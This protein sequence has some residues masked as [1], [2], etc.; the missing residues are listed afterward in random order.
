MFDAVNKVLGLVREVIRMETM[1]DS[2]RLNLVFMLLAFVVPLG[3]GVLDLAQVLIRLWNPTY[4]TGLP[5]FSVFATALGA[6]LACVA[7][8]AAIQKR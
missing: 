5:F 4:E 6:S 7:L 3:A 1:T 2:G 8:I